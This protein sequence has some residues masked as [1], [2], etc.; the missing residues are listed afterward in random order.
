MYIAKI[1]TTEII[2]NQIVELRYD[3]LRKPWNQSIETATDDLEAT[4]INVYIEEDGKIIA[5]GRLQNNGN[6]IGQ[7][8]YMAV[9]INHQGKG[10]GKLILQKLEEATSIQLKVIELHARDN[11]L[12]FYQSQGY[13]IK[14][15]SYKLWDIIQHYLMTK[16]I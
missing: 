6:G 16:T 1:A 14:E 2:I 7:I 4:S 9:S 13:A 10:L 15:K 5:C 11:A 12:H 8:R 3:V